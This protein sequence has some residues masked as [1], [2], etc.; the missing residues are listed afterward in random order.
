MPVTEL[1]PERTERVRHLWP[2]AVLAGLLLA[3]TA[4][5]LYLTRFHENAMYGD[6]SV[7]LTN[8]PQT[9][10]TNCEMVNTSGYSELAGI[11][12]SALGV[13]TYVL[14]FGMALAARRRPRLL[15]HIFTIGLLT[16]AYSGYLY[17]VSTVKIGYLCVW[18]FRLYCI[19]ASIPVLA[20]L[21]AWRNPIGLVGD[22][23]DDL[24][25]LAPDVRLGAALL[26]GLLFLT[27]LGDQF[28]RAGLTR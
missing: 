26:A 7:D 21:A 25:R 15:A 8:C 5:C 9:E 18:C 23:L 13:P 28:Y 2:L 19:N 16:V 27:I 20:A 12:I 1:S 6:S 22:S 24:K 11:P 17:Y 14:L 10:T 4:V 3:G